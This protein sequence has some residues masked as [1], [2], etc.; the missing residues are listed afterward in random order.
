MLLSELIAGLGI[1]IVRGGDARIGDLTEDSRTAVPG[2]LFVARRGLTSDGLSF[3]RD[4]ADAGAVAV[5]TG[6]GVDPGALPD[7]PAVAVCRDVERTTALLAERLHGNPS[8][9]LLVIGV[10]GTNGKTT[11]AHLVHQ[12]LNRSGLRCG[13]IGTIRVDDGTEIAPA[14]MTTPPAIE[15]SR[16]LAT[17]V[18]SGCDAAVMEVSSHAL[19]QARADGIAF[20]AGVFTNISGDHLDYHPSFEAYLAAKRRL[21]E[22]LGDR[23]PAVLNRDD[24]IVRNTPAVRPVTCSAEGD[25]DWTVRRGTPTLEGERLEIRGPDAAFDATV[26]L[27]GAHNAMNVAQA[28]GV[29]W[30]MLERAGVEPERRRKLLADALTLAHPPSGRLEPV[31]DAGDEVRVF[32]D[33]AH[34]DDALT[35]TLAAVREARPA[36]SALWVV[37]GCGGDRDRTK[38]SRMGLAASSGADRVVV[39]SDNPRTEPASRIVADILEGMPR[40]ERERARVHVDRE[41]AIHAAIA[42]AAP[43]DVV[44]IAGKGHETEQILPD[45]RGGTVARRFVDREVARAALARRRSPAGADRG[46][47]V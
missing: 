6:E 3:A 36:G 45:D 12:L 42:E 30:A 5:L 23:G 1:E 17:M 44:V 14:S 16:T 38:R 29:S 2:S 28:L 8:G 34:T 25:A 43:G 31:H 18:E 27:V 15:L 32:V 21:F 39:T 10:T 9:R 35:R 24:A 4:A 7:G 47:A 22:L 20:D 46:L 13:L 11:V 19:A 41:R 26:E 37:F 40:D 33:Y